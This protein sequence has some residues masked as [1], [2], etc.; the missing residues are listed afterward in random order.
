MVWT[1]NYDPL[2]NPALSTLLAAAPL[3]T[4]RYC[5]EQLL[6]GVTTTDACLEPASRVSR[7]MTPAFV[8]P[9]LRV[10][11][12]TRTVIEPLPTCVIVP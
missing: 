7:I 4:L 5:N 6:S 2:H 11:L 12:S 1:Q 9:S 3:V 10:R 8:Q